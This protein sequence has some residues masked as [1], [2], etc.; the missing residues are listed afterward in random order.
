MSFRFTFCPFLRRLGI[1]P[2]CLWSCSAALADSEKSGCPDLFRGSIGYRS[3]VN[4]RDIKVILYAKGDIVPYPIFEFVFLILYLP[5]PEYF[6][7][8]ELI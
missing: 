7:K 3:V 6:R 1:A 8:I 5:L 4:E 2:M